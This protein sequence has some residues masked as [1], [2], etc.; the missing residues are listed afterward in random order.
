M[1]KQAALTMRLTHEA[2]WVPEQDGNTAHPVRRPG[3]SR[4]ACRPSPASERKQQ[5]RRWR[6]L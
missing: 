1:Q 2:R 6:A 4:P 3:L 5:Q